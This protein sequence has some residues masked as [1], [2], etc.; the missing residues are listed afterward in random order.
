[1]FT[2]ACRLAYHRLLLNYFTFCEI[3]R[4]GELHPGNQALFQQFEELLSLFLQG[5]LTE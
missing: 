1:M 3:R 5:S 2:A 4:D